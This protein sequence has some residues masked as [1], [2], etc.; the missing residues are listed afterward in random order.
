M[1]G[2]APNGDVVLVGTSQGT[3]A[4]AVETSMSPIGSSQVF[5][6]RYDLSGAQ[7]WIHQLG[8]VFGNAAWSFTFGPSGNPIVTGV[9]GDV[10]PGGPI[11]NN[12]FGVFAAEYTI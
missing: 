11:A 1:I 4:G 2:F 6:A 7:K 8:G 5:V 3:V 10:L 9:A 12:G